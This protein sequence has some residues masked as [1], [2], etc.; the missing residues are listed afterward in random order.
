MQPMRFQDLTLEDQFLLD[1]AVRAMTNAYAPYSTR[2]VG[3]AVRS[4][5]KRMYIGANIEQATETGTICAEQA[6]LAAANTAG[7]RALEALALI[8][9]HHGSSV[10]EPLT[11]CGICRQYIYE[12]ADVAS[13]DTILIC[14]NTDKTKIVVGTIRELLPRAVGPHTLGV[15]IEAYRPLLPTPML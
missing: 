13:R 7:D 15:D 10:V 14:S 3:C 11:P 5:N 1:E 6:A 8:A 2:H 4:V 12:L 9:H